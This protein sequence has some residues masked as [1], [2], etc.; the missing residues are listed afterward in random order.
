MTKYNYYNALKEDIK[1]YIEENSIDINRDKDKLYEELF[2]KMW[3]EDSIT[4]NGSGSYTFNTYQAEEYICH[5][6]D[7]FRE[8]MEEFGDKTI[9]I[10]KIDAEYID[11]TIRCYL[12]S[13]VLSEVILHN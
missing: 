3:I 10:D 7:L 13:Q 12:L 1:N 9:P 2:D 11:V 8:A 6:L 5:N 4:G